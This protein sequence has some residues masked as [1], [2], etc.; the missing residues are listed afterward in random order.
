MPSDEFKLP[1][2]KISDTVIYGMV[3]VAG[4]LA[5]VLYLDNKKLRSQL[6][7]TSVARKPC[8]CQDNPPMEASPQTV[9]VETA[10]EAKPPE[11][12]ID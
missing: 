9:T 2:I 11:V 8:G 6:N 7:Q 10:V 12:V 4:V 3:V 5:I 1:Q